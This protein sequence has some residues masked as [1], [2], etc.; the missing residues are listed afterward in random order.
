MVKR[1]VT[2][3]PA[4]VADLCAAAWILN[5]P[6]HMHPLDP[7]E[8]RILGALVEKE[9]TTPDYYPLSLNALTLACNQSSNR[10][11]VMQL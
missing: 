11:P 8:L 2:R 10:D 7:V 6:A 9:R 1:D 3:Y 4:P 5:Q